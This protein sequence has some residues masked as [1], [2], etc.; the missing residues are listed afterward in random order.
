LEIDPFLPFLVCPSGG[1][2]CFVVRG[3]R[4]ARSVE[5]TLSR[6]LRPH[7]HGS[8]TYT[9][10]EL[11]ALKRFGAGDTGESR[12]YADGLEDAARYAARGELGY[13]VRTLAEGPRV[14]VS[15]VARLLSEGG[16]V[17]TVVSHERWFEDPDS[18]IAL[19][20]ASECSAELQALAEQMNEHWSSLRQARLLEIQA[21]Y[22][23]AEAEEDAA[24]ELQRI[25]E[26]ETN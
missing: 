8:D 5:I 22:D 18:Q 21:E 23:R 14:H 19:V 1:D 13:T 10:L 3:R 15:L 24:T 12:A 9:L 7:K 17:R 16:E 11:M 26:S 2:E 20:Q 6:D 25:V 4:V